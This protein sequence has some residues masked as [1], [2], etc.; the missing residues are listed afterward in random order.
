MAIDSKLFTLSSHKGRVTCAVG[1]K[2][3]IDVTDFEMERFKPPHVREG[4]QKH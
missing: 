1:T 3:V 4:V 2:P